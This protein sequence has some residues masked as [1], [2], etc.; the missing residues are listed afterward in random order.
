M[1]MNQNAQIAVAPHQGQIIAPPNQLP[2]QMPVFLPPTAQL[3]PSVLQQAP[4][5]ISH[6]NNNSVP[7]SSVSGPIASSETHLL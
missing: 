4:T 3:A 2:T 5:N 6:F 7:Y 1:S